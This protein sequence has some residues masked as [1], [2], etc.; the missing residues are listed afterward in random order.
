M[1]W[2][3]CATMMLLAFASC[4]TDAEGEL[5]NPEEACYSF[6]STQMNI[7]LTA[8]D[9]GVIR[10]PVYRGATADKA[11]I[12]V[13]AEMSQATEAIFH[14]TTSTV[15]FAAGETVAYAELNFG[16][17][18]NLGATNKYAIQLS[19]AEELLSPSGEGTIKI[20]AQRQLT[21]ESI[22]TGIYTSQLFNQSWEQPVEKAKEGNIY[23]LPD[24]IYEG[25]PFVFSLSEDG[26]ELL[27]WDLQ[28]SG[29]KHATYGMVYFLADGMVREGDILS[30]PMIGAVEYN[31]GFDALYQGFT[32]MLQLP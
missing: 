24:C 25:Y 18:D 16:T 27:S 12:A 11:T 31:G 23:R 6:A 7:E 5:Y 32:E 9:Q 15:T 3:V 1:N 29:Y 19:L 30:F 4:D 13:T 14:L 20:Q 22:G 26:Q 10:V 17:I 28:P 8:E 21:W 2:V